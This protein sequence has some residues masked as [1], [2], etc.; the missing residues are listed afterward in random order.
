MSGGRLPKRSFFE[1]L[2]VRYGEDGVGRRYW[3]P[4]GYRVISGLSA[5][6]GL[7]SVGEGSRG[8]GERVTEGQRR[9]MTK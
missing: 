4:I 8:V 2:R 5:Y 3:G 7:E 9:L 1:I 6:R